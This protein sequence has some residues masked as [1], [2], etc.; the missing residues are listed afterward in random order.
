[1]KG[2]QKM[3][4]NQSK[5]DIEALIQAGEGELYIVSG[6]G[7]IGTKEEYEGPQTAG[8]IYN[9]LKKERCGGDRWAFLDT[10][11]GHWSLLK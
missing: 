1:M 8:A 6:E 9:A 4:V 11:K 5:S 2:E 7:K 10:A 3:A